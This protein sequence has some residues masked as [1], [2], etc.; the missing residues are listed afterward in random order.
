MYIS[1]ND[2]QGKTMSN[3]LSTLARAV[4][5]ISSNEEIA[6]RLK[7][8]IAD[9]DDARESYSETVNALKSHNPN[10]GDELRDFFNENQHIREKAKVMLDKIEFDR[11]LDLSKQYLGVQEFR[12]FNTY[13][14]VLKY[15][16]KRILETS[17]ELV[18]LEKNRQ[19][20]RHTIG[21]YSK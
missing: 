16:S 5:Q 1:H 21:S 12:F 18:N 10:Y 7:L 15:T 6:Q 2:F 17:I 20:E 9:Y 4:F 13:E 11:D 3:F 14:H 8:A 19:R